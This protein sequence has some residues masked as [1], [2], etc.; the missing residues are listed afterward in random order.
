[1]IEKIIHQVKSFVKR[2]FSNLGYEIRKIPSGRVLRTSVGESYALIRALGFNPKTVIDVG[3]AGG[4]QDLY[5][6]FPDSLFL[7][8]EPL[9]EFESALK[10]IL[11]Q[12][13]GSYVLAAAG[14]SAGEV[15]FN[16]HDN[17][18]EGSSIYQD[19]MGAQADGHKVTVPMIRIDD[20]VREKSLSG[21]YLIKVDVQGA[22][23]S[24]L[25]GSQ[26]SLADAEV[27]VL[28]VC[29]FEFMKGAPQFFDVIYYMKQHSFAAYDIILGGNRPLDNALGYVDIVFVKENDQFRRDHSWGT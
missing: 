18:L 8:I 29:M 3:V 24:V 12:Y 11:K 25:E 22:E 21:P 17:Q 7:L 4:T 27:V 1:M 20:I 16:M 15:S 28:E 10:A 14:A 26:E 13:R 5:T 6:N 19:T 9:K 23:L 2:L